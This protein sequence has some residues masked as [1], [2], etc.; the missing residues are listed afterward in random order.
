MGEEGT[1]LFLER[2]ILPLWLAASLLGSMA[3]AGLADIRD[4]EALQRLAPSRAMSSP[5][6]GRVDEYVAARFKATGFECGQITFPTAVYVPGQAQVRLPGGRALPL[7]DM[8]PNT[9]HPGNLPGGVWEGRMVDIGKGTPQEMQGASLARAAVL[10]DIDSRKR[11]VSA[12][13][14]GAEILIFC[15][16]E[17]MTGRD[18]VQK[19]CKAPIAVPRFY[20][21][22]PDARAIRKAIS[23]GESVTVT[24][25]QKRPGR[26]ER[27]RA[28]NDW[29]I[30]PGATHAD[31]V[32]HLQAY[33]DA[34]SFAPELAPGAEGA[35]NLALLLR[36]LDHYTRNRPQCTL[37]FSAISDHCNGFRGEQFYAEAVL[38][39][40]RALEA[41]MEVRLQ[42]LKEAEFYARVYADRSEEQIGRLRSGTSFDAGRNLTLKGPLNRHLDYERNRLQHRIAQITYLERSGSIPDE[43]RDRVGEEKEALADQL[44]DNILILGILQRYGSEDTFSGL[45]AARQQRV[46][47]LMEQMEARF[48]ERATDFQAQLDDISANSRLRSLLGDKTSLLL[49]SLDISFGG[50]RTG[51][52]FQG[53]DVHGKSGWEASIVPL[54]RLSLDVAE[55]VKGGDRHFTDT[56]LKRS[57][58][59]W[60]NLLGDKFAV[61]ATAG[62]CVGLPSL[63]LTTTE[64]ARDLRFTPRDTL[65]HVD[66]ERVGRML[67]FSQVFLTRLLDHTDFVGSVRTP[68]ARKRACMTL[69]YNLRRSDPYSVEIPIEP[70]ANALVV[71]WKHG[72]VS[73]PVVGQVATFQTA[74]S[75]RQ[76]SAVFRAHPE[77]SAV[78]AY[79]F[80]AEWQAV[81]AAIDAGVGARRVNPNIT[82]LGDTWVWDDQIALL[83]DCA[84]TDLVGLYNPATRQPGTKGQIIL[85]DGVR[86]S[87]PDHYGVAGIREGRSRYTP[88]QANEGVACLFTEADA[89]TKILGGDFLLL[90]GSATA[91]TGNGF[92]PGDSRLRTIS[93]T[94][95]K[96]VQRLNRLRMERLH[97]KGIR[98]SAAVSLHREGDQFIAEAEQARREGNESE[99]LAKSIEG[100]G[101]ALNSYR[102]V[103]KTTTDLLKAVA[104][105][106]ALVFPFC[107]F[108]TKLT[109][110]WTDIRAQIASFGVIFITMALGLAVLHPAFGLSQTPMMVLVAF[111]MLGLAVFVMFI[112][113]TRFDSTLRQMVETAQGVESA[114]SSRRTLIGVAFS[115]G[116]NNMRRRRI[117]T[118]L[119]SLT[120]V[121]VTFTMLSVISVGQSQTPYNRRTETRS[122]YNGVLFAKPG[123]GVIEESEMDHVT[124]ILRRYGTVVRRTWTQRLDRYGGYMPFPVR[125]PAHPG[126]SLRANSLLGLEVA[127]N[128]FIRK[129]PLAAGRWFSRDD[130]Q[131][132]ILSVRAASILGIEAQ[133]FRPRRVL[134]RNHEMM[135]VGLMDDEA[136]GQCIDLARLPL[137][138]LASVPHPRTGAVAEDG[139]IS[140][141]QQDATAGPAPQ[142]H[143]LR[144]TDCAII[145]IEFALRIP[146]TTYRSVALKTRT[147]AAAWKAANHLTHAR[148]SLTYAGF[149]EAIEQEDGSS[150]KAGEYS[151][152]PPVGAV[153]GGVSKV[154]VPI[155]LA[156]TIILNTMLGAVMERKREIAIYNSIG[157]NPTHV[158]FFFVAEALVFGVIG[159][160]A[161]YLIGQG[162]A[163]GI[164]HFGWLPG[165]NLNY[166]SMAVMIVI[167]AAVVTVVISTLYPAYLATRAAVPSGQRRWKLPIP[168]GDTIRLDFPFSYREESLYGACAFLN[169]FMDLNSEASSGK[170]LAE[171]A[172]FGYVRDDSGRKVRSM[173]YSITPA[174]FDLGVNQRLAILA[175]YDDRVRAYVLGVRLKRLKGDRSS[176]LIVN[177]P[178]LESLRTRLLSW[179]SQSTVNQEEFG[180]QGE[181]MFADVPEFAAERGES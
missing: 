171:D 86:E 12:L 61:G 144:P 45:S 69:R 87:S 92:P 36:L 110:P 97:S 172:R 119:T 102:L 73:V 162:L 174:P 125:D 131:E 85:L 80:D 71:L 55:D 67:A 107:M 155:V 43:D 30:V 133:D 8:A 29:V 57:G 16:I 120:I 34:G 142:A 3:A 26:W 91:P 44:K 2:G 178:F 163:K 68:K 66:H 10:M 82:R 149:S 27:V 72:R 50:E 15:G 56:I 111:V 59:A 164:V 129:A 136:I 75:D 124:A 112:L 96:D 165:V 63:T 81:N 65:E 64:D 25:S 32:V 1:A 109:T 113:R 115:V 146:D 88:E 94:A 7:Y 51:F 4:V 108:L 161:G 33:K 100:Y 18:G 168:D 153:I 143:A 21:R 89:R 128:G 134:L 37:V 83:F 122:P 79:G 148:G 31:K 147:S 24:L 41:E 116:V 156:A 123:M 5:D 180:R 160:V 74:M 22:P 77:V 11:W 14:L 159:A 76:G 13:E 84:Q 154:V 151:L 176:W 169:A 39:D 54:A 117:R 173:A 62:Q 132:L 135:L 49:L 101:R 126:K 60:Q 175:R 42:G 179:R 170:F 28:R 167:L 152:V 99:F 17:R 90:N 118:T 166:S 53:S 78:E 106:L 19:I 47:D 103:R 137:L 95:A 130:A 181:A 9:V 48:R 23:S 105:F 145:P 127:E 140:V 46:L 141:S 6:R 40:R 20:L 157:L 98:A 114:E 35:A 150:V 104:V 158:F 93:Y 52:F 138:P 38:P 139:A 58:V 177:Q 121:L 70:V